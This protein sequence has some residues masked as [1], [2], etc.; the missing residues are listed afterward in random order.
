MRCD[1]TRIIPVFHGSSV[2]LLSCSVQVMYLYLS[3]MFHSFILKVPTHLLQS[4]NSLFRSWVRDFIIIGT[5]QSS[6]FHRINGLLLTVCFSKDQ[7]VQRSTAT[8][9]SDVWAFGAV[10]FA[11]FT[12]SFLIQNLESYQRCCSSSFPALDL[13]RF[14]EK[15]L[16]H[17]LKG[18]V[19]HI[20]YNCL[21]TEVSQRFSSLKV[22]RALA[23]TLW[24]GMFWG[25]GFSAQLT[26]GTVLLQEKYHMRRREN[27]RLHTE[28]KW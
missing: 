14:M 8:L 12:G 13:D 24:L 19:W 7:R 2:Q 27:L 5:M 21:K 20:A 11:I 6:L 23:G 25:A 4:L 26:W 3:V 15:R 9:V 28:I 16:R 10:V 22:H 17:F 18:N 1:M